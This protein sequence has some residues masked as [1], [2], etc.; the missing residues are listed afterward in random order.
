MRA[1]EYTTACC[2]FLQKHAN[3]IQRD[4]AVQNRRQIDFA[5]NATRLSHRYGGCFKKNYFFSFSSVIEMS[6]GFDV[7][8]M[9]DS[10]T[11]AI[12]GNG[13]ARE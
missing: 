11:I 2:V 7:F 6:G 13:I 10:R 3:R 5:K 9:N 12:R 8:L 4:P 1:Y